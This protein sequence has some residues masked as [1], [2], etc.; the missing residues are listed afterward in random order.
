MRSYVHVSWLNVSESSLY[1]SLLFTDSWNVFCRRNHSSNQLSKVLFK[2][3]YHCVA[4]AVNV[5]PRLR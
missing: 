5:V 2:T 3:N 4:T 1:Y